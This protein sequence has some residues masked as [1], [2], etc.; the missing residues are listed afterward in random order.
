ML[1]SSQSILA[2][3]SD[4]QTAGNLSQKVVGER[5]CAQHPSM[6]LSALRIHPQ[7]EQAYT[8]VDV[9]GAFFEDELVFEASC[10][11]SRETWTM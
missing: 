6:S 3:V 4:H 10:G 7:G 8:D 2:T 1:K 11:C 9:T 5:P